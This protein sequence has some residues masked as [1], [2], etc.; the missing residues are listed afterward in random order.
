MKKLLIVLVLS[1]QSLNSNAAA[2]PSVEQALCPDAEPFS[3]ILSGICWGCILP[4][5]V[6]GIG[7]TPPDGSAITDG[8]SID[9]ACSCPTKIGAPEIGFISG[10]WN[11]GHILEV[12][13][14]PMCSPALGGVRL[15]DS[16]DIMGQRGMPNGEGENLE[17]TVYQSHYFVFPLVAMLNLSS[18]PN[19]N[20]SGF[21]DMDLLQISEL[22]F[23]WVDD[24]AHMH[25]NMVG[26]M[27]GANPSTM[28]L[29]TLDGIEATAGVAKENRWMCMGAWGPAYP[30]TGNVTTNISPVRDSSLVSGRM[31]SR[32]HQMGIARRTMGSDALCGSGPIEPLIP[33]SQYKESMM[34]PVAEASGSSCCHQL[35]ANTFSWGEHRTHPEGGEDFLYMLWNWGE[36]CVPFF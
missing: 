6:F 27:I 3:M 33:K 30:L 8:L 11:P 31:L 16:M 7:G 36:G 22:F 9:N 2:P 13:R 19:L 5:N 18:M 12:V 10:F 35:G 17:K 29:C 1:F 20:H 23:D 26:L 32:S 28:A 34:Y 14:T 25:F 15:G 21:S 4:I 24:E